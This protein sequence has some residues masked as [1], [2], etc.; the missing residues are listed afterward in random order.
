MIDKCLPPK[1]SCLP[2]MSHIFFINAFLG[3]VIRDF[4][5]IIL[6]ALEILWGQHGFLFSVTMPELKVK[7]KCDF[8]TFIEDLFS[9]YEIKEGDNKVINLEELPQEVE[10]SDLEKSL[11]KGV[12]CLFNEI[13]KEQFSYSIYSW[14]FSTIQ[15]YCTQEFV[16]NDYRDVD[17]FLNP[18][19]LA[20]V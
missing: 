17:S 15:Y 14:L 7:S 3:I 1:T 13:Y 18:W 12:N 4:S 10:M 5:C 20:V 2:I 16:T 19:G 9:E 6:I 8:V 11:T